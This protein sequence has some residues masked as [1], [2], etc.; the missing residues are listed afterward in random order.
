MGLWVGPGHVRNSWLFMWV[1]LG[2]HLQHSRVES[3]DVAGGGYRLAQG[4]AAPAEARQ[5]GLTSRI[6]LFCGFEFVECI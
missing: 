4:P 2:L 6:V 1:C 3:P 5:H